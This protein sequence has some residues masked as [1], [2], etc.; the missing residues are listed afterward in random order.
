LNE[1]SELGTGATVAISLALG[2]I[3]GL[4]TGGLAVP[5]IAGLGLGAFGGGFSTYLEEEEEKETEEALIKVVNKLA[6]SEEKD[7]NGYLQNSSKHLAELLDKNVEELTNAERA[8]LSN[9]SEINA[10]A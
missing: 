7:L 4:A 1:L 3:F 5:I 8:L 10:L 6:E 9:T 2:G